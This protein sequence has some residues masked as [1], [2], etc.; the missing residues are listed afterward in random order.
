LELRLHQR[1]DG[2]LLEDLPIELEEKDPGEPV[3]AVGADG[4]GE[5]VERRPVHAAGAYSG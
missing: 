1:G 2:E 3:P 5:P 4:I